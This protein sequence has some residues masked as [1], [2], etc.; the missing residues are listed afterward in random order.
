MALDGSSVAKVP[1]RPHCSEV[2]TIQ[3]LMELALPR[4]EGLGDEPRQVHRSWMVSTESPDP[5]GLME[6]LRSSSP[7]FN[8]DAL[9]SDEGSVGISN[10]AVTLLCSSDDG[11][12]P[13]NSDQVLSDE[14]LPPEAGSDERRQV[15]QIRDISL[16]VQIVDI[17]QV[18]RAWD[19]RRTVSK[20]GSGKRMPLSVCVPATATSGRDL[21]DAPGLSTDPFP[22][23]GGVALPAMGR[24]ETIQLSSPPR[25]GHLLGRLPL[26]IWGTLR[27][28]CPLIVFG[29]GI[30]RRFRKMAGCL[31]CRHF[32]QDF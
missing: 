22:V 7:C 17:S 25:S 16:D 3:A 31:T 1:V 2:Q 4:F 20:R 11:H 29:R 24:V 6:P 30:H 27:F 19:S 5:G 21:D 8:L 14:D 12:T 18:G 26:R 32:L 9:S 28:H 23:V 15:I 10:I 13:V